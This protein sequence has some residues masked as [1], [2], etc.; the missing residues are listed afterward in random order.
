MS[1]QNR[2]AQI[3]YFMMLR[4]F[5][6]R[7]FANLK[8]AWLVKNKEHVKVYHRTNQRKNRA[9]KQVASDRVRALRH[10]A[11]AIKLKLDTLG[12]TLDTKTLARF[13]RAVLQK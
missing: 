12:E 1:T 10:L 9:V 7:K 4:R 5:D 2:K 3:T 8:N 13:N 6:T 11:K